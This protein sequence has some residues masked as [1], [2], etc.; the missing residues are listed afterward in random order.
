[1]TERGAPVVCLGEALVDLVSEQP[2]ARLADAPSFV[3]RFGG[4][5]ANI[6]VGAARFGARVSMLGGAGTDDWGR[7][8]REALA[9]EGVDVSRFRLLDGT[10]TPHAFVAVSDR[11]EPS[12][13]FFG[14]GREAAVAAL[15]ED[16]DGV[17]TAAE[18][19]VLV[20]GSDTLNGESERAV[21][22]SVRA[23]ALE[24]GWLV[25]YD[26][27]L[28]PAR[29]P[30]AKA[31]TEAARA[32]LPG[33][34]LVKLSGD[35]AMA[36]TRASMPSEAARALVR[37][38]AGAT[39]VTLGAEGMLVA[40][41]G[42]PEPVLVRSRPA[43]AAAAVVD[44]TGAGDSVAAVMAAALARTLDPEVAPAVAEL[45]AGTARSVVAERGAL[46]GLPSAREARRELADVL[47]ERYRPTPA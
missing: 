37:A 30:D 19:G 3:P 42:S 24:R 35:E 7:W 28:R 6:A 39:V 21:T 5:V 31:L 11:G 34:A 23:L 18:P 20:L 47:R 41:T 36:L 32:V 26:P 43:A 40:T 14:E 2:V 8:L 12:Y 29:W 38:D 22:M 33:A 46:A 17:I 15:A 45:A 9:A 27:N 44:A 10:P 1:V 25:L 13:V 16:L 4:S